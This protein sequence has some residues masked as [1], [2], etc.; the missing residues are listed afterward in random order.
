M[1]DKDLPPHVTLQQFDVLMDY[2]IATALW[3]WF[4]QYLPLHFKRQANDRYA[5]APRAKGYLMGKY[6]GKPYFGRFP[7]LPRVPLDAAKAI[8]VS[9][10]DPNPIFHSGATK[11]QILGHP[12]PPKVTRTR[13]GY[14]GTMKL[15]VPT[16]IFQ[17]RHVDL[18]GE[19]K[20][21]SEEEL[22]DLYDIIWRIVSV[23]LYGVELPQV[24]S[25]VRSG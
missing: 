18:I 6:R 7:N 12:S 23:G 13:G 22:N 4:T 5:Y 9:R 11:S 19:L 2:A 20:R 10:K 16:H 1:F 8:A 17:N 3:Y 14:R 21:Y 25:S 15:S 24:L